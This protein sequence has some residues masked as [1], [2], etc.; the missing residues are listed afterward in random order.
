MNVTLN[1]SDTGS[2]FILTF[3]MLRNYI[4]FNNIADFT[5]F[6]IFLW[7]LLMERYVCYLESVKI[8]K[9]SK[10]MKKKS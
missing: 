9:I 5:G 1:I 3:Q 10:N 4:L 7:A 2:D 8:I 6:I